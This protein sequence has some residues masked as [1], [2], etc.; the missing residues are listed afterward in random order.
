MVFN[1]RKFIAK[2]YC[3]W[4]ASNVPLHWLCFASMKDYGKLYNRFHRCP[5]CYCMPLSG[6]IMAKKSIFS[7][8]CYLCSIL[9]LSPPAFLGHSVCWALVS[10]SAPHLTELTYHGFPCTQ[11][12]TACR[13]PH[14]ERFQRTC[15]QVSCRVY[16]PSSPPDR[17]GQE[18][19]V[20][21][22]ALHSCWEPD[23][24]DAE[25][26]WVTSGMGQM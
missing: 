14:S 1:W 26:G 25:G 8:R 21:V 17:V 19:A 13:S 4:K 2:H 18:A 9:F 10:Q 16:F 20:P 12:N 24:K 7:S 5:P 15:S 11:R 6:I 22:V 23:G 3:S